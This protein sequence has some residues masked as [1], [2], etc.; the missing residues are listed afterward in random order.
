MKKYISVNIFKANGEDWSNGGL[1]SKYNECYVECEDGWI[2]EDRVPQDAIVQIVSNAFGTIA[3]KPFAPVEKDCVGYMFGGC[4]ISSSD[5]RFSKICE[6][7][8]GHSFHGAVALHD[9]TE[10]Q[11]EYNLLSM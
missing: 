4:Y 8:L 3:A 11:K 6:K 7:L 1:S 10:T 2:T 9:R 5:S